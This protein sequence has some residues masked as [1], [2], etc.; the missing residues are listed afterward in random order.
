[1]RRDVK[2]WIARIKSGHD[3]EERKSGRKKGTEEERR[4]RE[5]CSDPG[6]LLRDGHAAGAAAIAEGGRV[7]VAKA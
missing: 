6:L 3:K 7:T 1:M 4:K 5:S 2:A